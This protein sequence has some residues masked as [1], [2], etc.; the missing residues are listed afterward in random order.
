[1]LNCFGTAFRYGAAKSAV[2]GLTRNLALDEGKH[3]IRVNAVSPGY[4]LTDL[5][6]GWLAAE[7]GRTEKA[8][9]I[10]PLSQLHL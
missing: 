9:S 3:E 8:N 7:S 1:M 2:L 4:I 10:Q 6:K 5:T